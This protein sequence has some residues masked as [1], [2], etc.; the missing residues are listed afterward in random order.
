MSLG[1]LVFSAILSAI[2]LSVVAFARYE[3]NVALDFASSLILSQISQTDFLKM[4][5][6]LPL[7][8]R[9]NVKLGRRKLSS[10][11]GRFCIVMS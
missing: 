2:A 5:L 3:S 4:G 10:V 8:I 9:Y 6:H 11:A 1:S 7:I